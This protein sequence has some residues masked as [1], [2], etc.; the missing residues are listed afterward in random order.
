MIVKS[1]QLCILLVVIIDPVGILGLSSLYTR[2][3][4]MNQQV[5]EHFQLEYCFR[6]CS[7]SHITLCVC[8]QLYDIGLFN[9]LKDNCLY[10]AF[11]ALIMRK[12]LYRG[13]GGLSISIVLIIVRMASV[14]QVCGLTSTFYLWETLESV[15]RSC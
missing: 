9:C 8:C 5:F 12:S 3:C 7:T 6:Y 2:Y 4:S 14:K 11:I 10:R 1:T 13:L 15:N